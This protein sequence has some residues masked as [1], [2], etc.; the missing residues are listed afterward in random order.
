[1]RAAE[2]VPRDGINILAI[3]AQ[4]ALANPLSI[5]TIRQSA[6][7]WYQRDKEATATANSNARLLLHWIID[8][9]IGH[10]RARAFLVRSDIRHPLLD[11]LF[12]S[13]VLHVLKKNISAHDQPGVR[14]NAFKLDYGCYVDLLTT[15]R[16]PVGLLPAEESGEFVD[17]PP[18]D[19]RAIRTAI[20]DIDRF[21]EQPKLPA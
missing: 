6:S 17:V 8:E 2:G 7:T 3:A 9:V 4:K 19:Y 21:E 13:R 5:P 10:R 11:A 16:A 20:L 12:D 1:M 14:Y 18:D 15:V